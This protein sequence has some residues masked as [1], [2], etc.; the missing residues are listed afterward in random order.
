MKKL[1]TF[2]IVRYQ[3]FRNGLPDGIDLRNVTTTI[4]THSDVHSGEFVLE[5]EK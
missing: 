5:V 4:N 1:L 2:L 3:S